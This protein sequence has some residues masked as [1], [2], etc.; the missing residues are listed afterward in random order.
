MLSI[1]YSPFAYPFFYNDIKYLF[2]NDFISKY[3]NYCVIKV[4]QR[5]WINSNAIN[6]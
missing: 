3:I 1:N 5:I 2:R 6:K 4:S